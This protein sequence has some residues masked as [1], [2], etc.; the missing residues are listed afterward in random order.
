MPAI[1]NMVFLI[2][3]ELG[4]IDLGLWQQAQPEPLYMAKA[5]NHE[6]G[7]RMAIAKSAQTKAAVFL[8]QTKPQ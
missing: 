7:G 6:C 3:A 5:R 2:S 8:P 1:T 4:S